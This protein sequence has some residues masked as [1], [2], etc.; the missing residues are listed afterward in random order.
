MTKTTGIAITTTTG[1]TA[2]GGATTGGARINTINTI[3]KCNMI[4]KGLSKQK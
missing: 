3:K 2:N 4:K 1:G